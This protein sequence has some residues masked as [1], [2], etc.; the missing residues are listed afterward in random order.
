MLASSGLPSKPTERCHSMSRG[1]MV[2]MGSH[3]SSHNTRSAA[4]F[5]AAGLAR[6]AS[7][8]CDRCTSAN[9]SCPLHDIQGD[10]QRCGS[11]KGRMDAWS[12]IFSNDMQLA[13]MAYAIAIRLLQ[14][15]HKPRALGPTQ[16]A[17]WGHWR[18]FA[19][20]CATAVAAC[21]SSCRLPAPQVPLNVQASTPGN[22]RT[23]LDCKL[24]PYLRPRKNMSALYCGSALQYFSH[25]PQ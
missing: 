22:R 9:K 16:P 2:F 14:L 1:Y 19:S 5:S 23:G 12:L 10:L 11:D 25:C 13:K 17:G 20:A 6:I 7:A 8:C 4:T 3:H 18:L 21:A 24:L 15:G